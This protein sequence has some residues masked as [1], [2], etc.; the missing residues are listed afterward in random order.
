MDGVSRCD[1]ILFLTASKQ[2]AYDCLLVLF[3]PAYTI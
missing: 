3:V 2:L 1:F